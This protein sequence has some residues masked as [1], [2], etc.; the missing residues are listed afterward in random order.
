MKKRV[1][2]LLDK[3]AETAVRSSLVL[4]G[5]KPEVIEKIVEFYK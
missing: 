3:A 1:E 2:H 5:D 4:R